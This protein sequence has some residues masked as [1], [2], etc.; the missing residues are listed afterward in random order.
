VDMLRALALRELRLRPREVKVV[1]EALVQGSLRGSHVRE[2]VLA[3]PIPG[4]R[5]SVKPPVLGR[6]RENPRTGSG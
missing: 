6:C 2:F 4:S 5:D 3:A 1:T